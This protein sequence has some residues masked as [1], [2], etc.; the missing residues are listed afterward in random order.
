M[1]MTLLRSL[2]TVGSFLAFLGIVFWAYSARHRDYLE[3]QGRVVLEDESA[4]NPPVR[5]HS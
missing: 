1:D 3:L 2:V 4:D 5:D